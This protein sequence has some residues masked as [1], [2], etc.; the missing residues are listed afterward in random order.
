MPNAFLKNLRIP[1]PGVVWVLAFIAVGLIGVSLVIDLT[2]ESAADQFLLARGSINGLRAYLWVKGGLL[3]AFVAAV[4]VHVLNGGLVLARL[5]QSRLFG[6]HLAVHRRV[7]WGIGY[8]FVVLGSSLVALSVTTLVALNACW[9]M[10]L[11]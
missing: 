7:R 11:L 4:G 3:A 10:R 5:G 8:V 1:R 6:I 2:G 9:Y